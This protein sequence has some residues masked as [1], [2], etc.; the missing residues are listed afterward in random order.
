MLPESFVMR[1]R[2]ETDR[3]IAGIVLERVREDIEVPK[4]RRRRAYMQCEPCYVEF[5]RVFTDLFIVMPD[6]KVHGDSEPPRNL[7]FETFVPPPFPS[8]GLEKIL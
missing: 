5:I 4:P 3:F 8:C 2:Q 7:L 6:A 1:D